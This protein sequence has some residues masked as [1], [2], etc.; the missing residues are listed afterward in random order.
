MFLAFRFYLLEHDSKSP[1]GFGIF[2]HNRLVVFY[3]YEA[4]IGDGLEDQDVHNDPAEKR[5]EAMRM[6]INVVTYALLGEPVLR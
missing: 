4:D 5:E 1:Q 2:D 6:A 3:T